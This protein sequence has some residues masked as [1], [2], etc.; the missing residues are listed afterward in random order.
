[1]VATATRPFEGIKRKF[2]NGAHERA[3]ATAKDECTASRFA[4]RFCR[5]VSNMLD[6]SRVLV[7]Y[8]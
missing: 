5:E 6:I 4:G 3:T 7:W 2:E 8:H 1:M